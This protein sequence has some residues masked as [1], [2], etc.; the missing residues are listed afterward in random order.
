MMLKSLSAV[1]LAAGMSLSSLAFAQPQRA[2][3]RAKTT[4][5]VKVVKVENGRRH[6]KVIKRERVKRQ[7]RAL[8]RTARPMALQHRAHLR[9]VGA[10]RT[11]KTVGVRK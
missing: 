2:M 6:L 5:V 1:I 11:V 7:P 4:R 10:R 3:T 8:R 9:R